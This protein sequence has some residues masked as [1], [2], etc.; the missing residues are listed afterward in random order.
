[1]AKPRIRHIALNVRNRALIIRQF[2]QAC[3][4]Q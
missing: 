4:K 1:M 2:S 3:C